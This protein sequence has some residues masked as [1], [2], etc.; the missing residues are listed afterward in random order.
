MNEADEEN[1]GTNGVVLK[2]KEN[3]KSQLKETEDEHVSNIHSA[4]MNHK[5]RSNG[6]NDDGDDDACSSC[7]QHMPTKQ[8]KFHLADRPSKSK[9]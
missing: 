7:V 2:M 5:D 6:G 4:C 3:P 1:M 9:N 8:S